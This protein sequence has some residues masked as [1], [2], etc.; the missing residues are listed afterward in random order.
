MQLYNCLSKKKVH[1][2]MLEHLTVLFKS[3]FFQAEVGSQPMQ[4]QLENFVQFRRERNK[5]G[6]FESRPNRH[7]PD[8]FYY[9]LV[10][11]Y[12]VR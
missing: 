4:P 11:S 9:L 8:L 12:V 6:Q 2:E 10:S 5:A 3:D 1:L 7:N